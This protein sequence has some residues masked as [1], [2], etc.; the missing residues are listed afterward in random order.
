MKN[1]VKRTI[2]LLLVA[3]ILFSFSMVVKA[4]PGS[5]WVDLLRGASLGL[6]LAGTISCIMI[7]VEYLRSNK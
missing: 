5:I 4:E 2:Y 1:K 6:A 3:V 7:I